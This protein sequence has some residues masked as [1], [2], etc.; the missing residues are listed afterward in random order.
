MGYRGILCKEMGEHLSFPTLLLLVMILAVALT[1]G[2]AQSPEEVVI[3]P[4]NFNECRD[5]LDVVLDD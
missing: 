4:E 2:H 3:Y 1:P 5:D